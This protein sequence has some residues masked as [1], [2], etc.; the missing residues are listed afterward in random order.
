MRKRS[1]V[2]VSRFNVDADE[3]GPRLGKGLHVAVRL[4]QH[5]VRIEKK[6]ETATSKSSEGLR[7]KREVWH[8]MTVH[9][10]EV[11]PR[12]VQILHFSRARGEVRVITSEEGRGE[13][14]VVHDYQ[15]SRTA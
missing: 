5:Q 13:N 6:S 9:D 11:Q 10:I 2:I 3:I 4:R 8:E 7:T 14:C 1:R 12:K 15:T